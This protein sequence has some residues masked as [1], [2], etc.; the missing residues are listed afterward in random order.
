MFAYY[1]PSARAQFSTVNGQTNPLL[2]SGSLQY[3]ST[4]KK[5]HMYRGFTT[6]NGGEWKA[7]APTPELWG[8]LV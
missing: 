5:S 7:G 2:L 1:C 4:K 8:F 3:L 6:E